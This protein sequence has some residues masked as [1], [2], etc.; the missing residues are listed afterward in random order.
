MRIRKSDLHQ[1][2]L[3]ELENKTQGEYQS[4]VYIH[5]CVFYISKYFA[6][7]RT[8][9]K[10]AFRSPRSILPMVLQQE[11]IAIARSS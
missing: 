6:S 4:Q 5:P 7:R 11:P 8:S 9:F 2:S 10:E 1:D 3:I